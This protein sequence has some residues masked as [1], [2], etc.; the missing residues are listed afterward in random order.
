MK[1]AASRLP[2]KKSNIDEANVFIDTMGFS[3]YIHSTGIP[4]AEIISLL[5]PERDQKAVVEYVLPR[6]LAICLASRERLPFGP[7][8]LSS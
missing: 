5:E 4:P 1:F 7:L 3:S 6:L 8:S 2:V